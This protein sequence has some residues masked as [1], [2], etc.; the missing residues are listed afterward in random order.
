MAWEKAFPGMDAA[1]VTAYAAAEGIDLEWE[2]GGL[3]TRRRRPAVRSTG[4]DAAPAWSNLLAFCSEWTMN[5]AVRDFLVTTVGRSGLQF[6]TA[7]GNGTPFPASDV[8]TVH[9]A[10]ER[11]TTRI[12][13]RAGDV[14]LLDNIRTAHSTEPYTGD[15]ELAVMH[16]TGI[17]G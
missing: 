5:P 11:A 8:E 6:E 9:D 10:Y 4:T 7:Y 16:A 14:L 2:P 3:T 17:A 13:W 1:A 12:A 15:R